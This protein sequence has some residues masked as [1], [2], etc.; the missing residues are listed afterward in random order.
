IALLPEER[1]TQGLV[2]L[3]SVLDNLGL[4]LLPSLS[5]RGFVDD[6]KLT[7]VAQDMVEHMNIKTPSL[8]Q[9]TMY[10][11]GGNQQKVVLGKWFARNCD[12][13]LFDEPTRGI[14][15]GAKIEIYHLMNKLIE[16]GSTI[17]MVSSELPEILAMSD[18][19]LVMREGR[20]M[21]ELTRE[22]ATKEAILQLA[23]GR[24]EEYARVE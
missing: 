18:R 8:F 2:L 11:S 14:D 6:R 22:E 21:G 5:N 15:V 9:K 1:K 24:R 19:I 23:L 17:I 3:L 13:Y 10:L 7:A 4:P 16:R 20:V 12:I